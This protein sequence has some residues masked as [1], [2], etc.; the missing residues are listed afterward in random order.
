MKV[1][2]LSALPLAVLVFSTLA[3]AQGSGS[4]GGGRTPTASRSYSVTRSIEAKIVSIDAERSL[5]AVEL[6]NGERYQLTV[7][8]KTK[9]KADKK[10]SLRGKKKL[11]LADFEPG[12]TI[13]VK[14]RADS[15]Q[16]TEV[17][18]KKDKVVEKA[19]TDT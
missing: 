7:H 14:Y 19:G 10:T 9:Y 4:T 12:Q 18:L 3:F 15:G 16:V 2:K 1:G 8:E 5:V 6:D 11:S 13:K 17:R